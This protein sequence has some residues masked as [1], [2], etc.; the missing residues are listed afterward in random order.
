MV[1][2]A[3][4]R[5]VNARAWTPEEKVDARAGLGAFNTKTAEKVLDKGPPFSNVMVARLST[6]H[7]GVIEL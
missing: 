3:S 5:G 6:D 4:E 7:K 2:V 1:V